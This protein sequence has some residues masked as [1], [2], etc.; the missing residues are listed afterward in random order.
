MI[1]SAAYKRIIASLNYCNGGDARELSI[2]W[3]SAFKARIVHGD[4]TIHTVFV[5]EPCDLDDNVADY[6]DAFAER[7]AKVKFNQFWVYGSAVSL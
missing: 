1:L 5:S 7:L 6:L 2:I 4:S 3:V